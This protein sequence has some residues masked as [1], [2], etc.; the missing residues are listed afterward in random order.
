MSVFASARHRRTFV[1]VAGVAL[2][3]VAGLSLLVGQYLPFLTNGA[4]LRAFVDG[5][6]AFAPLV[7]VGLQAGQ[8]LLAPIPGQLTGFVSGYLFG[9]FLGTVY[10][11]VGVTIGST[12]AFWLSRRYGRPFVERVL[13]AEVMDR[14]DAF[15]DQ[16]GLLSLFVMFLLPGLPDDALCFVGGLTEIDLWKL[17]AIMMVGRLPGYV[18]VNVSGASLATGDLRLAVALVLVVV[19]FTVWG[20]VRRE[21]IITAVQQ[22]G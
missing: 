14:F 15:V 21:Q 16:A 17:V 22:L 9:G 13:R 18:L 11:L 6:G 2:L 20:V 4:E 8:V 1:L 19:G 10:S 7:F 12:I 5:Y 3:G